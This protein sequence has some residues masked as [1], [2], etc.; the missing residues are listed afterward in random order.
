MSV[1]LQRSRWRARGP[2]LA[3]AIILGAIGPSL[4]E[5]ATFGIAPTRLSLDPGRRS[6]AV[7]LTNEGD[8]ATLVQVQTFAW[9]GSLS[10]AD[11]Q[12]TRELLAVPAVF[13]L[14]PGAKQIIRVALRDQGDLQREQSYRLLITEVPTNEQQNDDGVRFSIRLS[15]PVFM[16][17]DDAE[18]NASWSVRAGEKGPELVLANNGSAH[19][20]V[21]RLDLS[22][23]PN[24]A[25][26]E[27]SIEA[28][29]YVLAGQSH[30]WPLPRAPTGEVLH[31]K[32]ETNIGELEAMVP[33]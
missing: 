3:L 13:S 19:L 26:P 30:A 8:S 5:A 33:R 29:A 14:E 32:A 2:W 28:P 15:L 23:T 6:G 12:P 7:T 25:A 27:A 31:L 10:S 4:V 18:P 16:T 24:A 21:E 22:S 9:N 1:S 20:R 17:P 11:L